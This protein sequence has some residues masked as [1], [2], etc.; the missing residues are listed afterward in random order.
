MSQIPCTHNL[1]IKLIQQCVFQNRSTP[2]RIIII[3]GSEISCHIIHV[4]GV[5][6]AASQHEAYRL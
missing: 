4:I 6:V 3:T 2:P 5:L 1:T